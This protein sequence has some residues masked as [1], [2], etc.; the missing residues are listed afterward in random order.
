MKKL[1]LFITFTITTSFLFG[2]QNLSTIT[3]AGGFAIA[4]DGSSISWTMGE[5]FSHTENSLIVTEGFQQGELEL[6]QEVLLKAT[7][8]N[9]Q[10]VRLDLEKIGDVNSN[11]FVI[12]RSIG[13]M[14]NF[15]TINH[16]TNQTNLKK[17]I[18]LDANNSEQVSYY[19]VLYFNKEKRQN[20]KSAQAKGIKKAIRIQTFPNPTTD[21]IQVQFEGKLNNSTTIQILSANG[22]IV[23]SN[24][25]K[26]IN[27]QLISIPQVESLISGNY[28][29]Q[30]IGEDNEVLETI[31]FI[32]V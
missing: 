29:L 13:N 24:V 7:R 19:K 28:I 17:E 12:Q 25:Y 3:T 4:N 20:T 15:S 8:I 31:K 10:Y 30:I 9:N 18:V 16:I 23:Y 14:K 2:Q 22:S 26:S 27:N 11:T 6:K 1:L 5:V 21:Y 32:K